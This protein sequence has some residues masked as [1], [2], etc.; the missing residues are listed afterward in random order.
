MKIKRNISIDSEYDNKMKKKIIAITYIHKVLKMF[1]SAIDEKDFM[2]GYWDL[3]KLTGFIKR[4]KDK[5][6]ADLRRCWTD[7]RTHSTSVLQIAA[8]FSSTNCGSRVWR[9]VRGIGQRSLSNALI[10]PCFFN[11][12]ASNARSLNYYENNFC[13]SHQYT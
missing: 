5:T 13:F 6:N 4:Y 2:I 3:N 10:C 9:G 1:T 7:G 8:D 12:S 11:F